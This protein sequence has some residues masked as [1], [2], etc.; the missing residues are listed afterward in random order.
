[1]YNTN[2]NGQEARL[3]DCPY[4]SYTAVCDHYD[5][6]AV[7]CQGMCSNGGDL[8]LVDSRHK[9]NEG[10]V[11]VCVNGHWGT[12]CGDQ[13]NTTNTQVVCRQDGYYGKYYILFTCEFAPVIHLC[14]TYV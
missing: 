14:C 13:W 11:M 1:M 2:C 6:L 3:V 4:R 9:P 10:R 7:S 5:D 8:R 12:V